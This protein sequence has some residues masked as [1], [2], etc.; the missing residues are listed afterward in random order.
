MFQ[1]IS[2]RLARLACRARDRRLIQEQQ[3]AATH[4]WQLRRVA[5]ATYQFRDPRFDRLR[6]RQAMRPPVQIG[7][8]RDG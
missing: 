2:A 5:P 4:G 1:A 6:T 8:G 7:G 3:I